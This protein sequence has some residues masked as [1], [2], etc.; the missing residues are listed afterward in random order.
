MSNIN[1]NQVMLDLVQTLH[2]VSTTK[3]PI[4]YDRHEG[5]IMDMPLLSYMLNWECPGIAITTFTQDGKQETTNVANIGDVILSGIVGEQYVIPKR[6]FF[7]LYD[8]TKNG[9][10]VIP[11]QTPRTVAEVSLPHDTITFLAPWGTPMI[12]EDKD[13]LVKDGVD[14]YR[15]ARQEFLETYTWNQ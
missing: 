13:F 11:N 9:R 14:Y 7:Q 5:D 3:Q 6:K 12:L 2:W 10:T 15:I 4:E 1:G 8:L